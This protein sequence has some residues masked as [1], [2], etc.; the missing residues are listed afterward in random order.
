MPA[1]NDQATDVGT[2]LANRAAVVTGASAGIG[3]SVALSLASKGAAVVVNARR[4]ERLKALVGEIESAGGRAF[5]VP[6]DCAEQAVID[7]MLDAAPD[8]FDRQADLVVANAGRGLAGSVLSS[9]K[10]QWDEM[11]RT[12]VTAAAALMRAA[13]QRMLEARKRDDGDPTAFPPRDLVVIGSNVGKHISPFSSMYGSTKFAVGS[14]AEA[15]RRELGPKGVRV[16]LISPGI[17]V[18]EFQ[19]VA[20]YT[21]DLVDSFHDKFDPL[22]TPDDVARLITFITSQPAHVHVN[23]AIIRPTRQDYP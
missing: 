11:V 2:L 17:V 14:L 6:G 15:V 13:G 16:S 18:S 3:R 9:D 1:A 4:V 8:R 20:G 10:S 22:L 5:A 12:N 23:D 21:D 7:A 19:S